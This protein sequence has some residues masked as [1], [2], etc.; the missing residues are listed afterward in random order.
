MMR[1]EAAGRTIPITKTL[2][3]SEELHALQEVFE[4]GWV[5]QGPFVARFE[6]GFSRY[7]NAPHAV[8]TSS[9]T[10]ALHIAVAALGLG[11]GD[12]VI[13]PAF[14]WVATANVVE[15]MGATPVF[16]DVDLRTFNID[17]AAIEPLITNRTVGIIPVHLFGLCANMQAVLEIARRR[18]LWVVE[19]AACA[20]GGFHEGRH[21]GTM[22]DLGCFSF[23]PRKSITTGEGGMITTARQDYDQLARSLRDHGASRSDL[24]RHTQT[25]SFLLAEYKRLGYNY[26]MTDIQGAI[27]C[28]QMDRLNWILAEKARRARGYDEQL[29]GLD[30]LDPPTA[31]P[32]YVHGYQAYV[33]LFRPDAARLADVPR[34]HARRNA[35]MARLEERGISTRQGTHAVTLQQYYAEKYGLRPEQFPNSYRADRLTL[36]LPLY[37]QMTD[38]DQACV[39]TE[40]RRAFADK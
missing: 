3:G 28:A 32:G 39:V 34:L 31:A 14:T 9:C 36:A 10:T 16:C 5:V 26:R 4:S 12:E 20:L 11:P 15:Y 17:T 19:D 37:P 29:R 25:S 13:V 7:T 24:A 33:C 23:H 21:A 2:F 1:P 27:G 6:E 8:A 38:D 22:G 30:W 18:R 35:L 40:L